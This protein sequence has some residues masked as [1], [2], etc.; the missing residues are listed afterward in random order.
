MKAS[1]FLIKIDKKKR[2]LYASTRVCNKDFQF[3]LKVVTF[4]NKLKLGRYYY[5]YSF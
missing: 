4:R 3:D 2:V 5:V 1:S